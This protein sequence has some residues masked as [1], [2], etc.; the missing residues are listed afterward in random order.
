MGARP[1]PAEVLADLALL[2]SMS[3]VVHYFWG[4]WGILAALA[5]AAALEHGPAA[6]HDMSA[7]LASSQLTSSAISDRLWGPAS[8]LGPAEDEGDETRIHRRQNEDGANQAARGDGAE[9]LATALSDT[10]SSSSASLPVLPTATTATNPFQGRRRDNSTFG[11]SGDSDAIAHDANVSRLRIRDV[12]SR[13]TAAAS[14]IRPPLCANSPAPIP[15]ETDLFVGHV[16]FLV[17]TPS[18]SPSAAAEAAA[19]YAELFEGKRRMFWIQVQGRFKRAPRGAVFLGGE[20]PARIAPGFFTR[21]LALVIVGLIRQLL[22]VGNV[23]FSFGDDGREENPSRSRSARRGS[24][25]R[26]TRELPAISFPLYQSVD[27]FVDT[28]E[29]EEP[30]ELGSIDFGETLEMRQRRRQTPLGAEKFVVGNTYSFHFHTMYVDLTKW[31]TVNLPGLSAMDLSAFFDSLPLRLVAYDVVNLI[32]DDKH[33]QVDKD[34]LFSFEIQYDR[35]RTGFDGGRS[36]TR[37]ADTN[38]PVEDDDDDDLMM[39]VSS[40]SSSSTR[41]SRAAVGVGGPIGSDLSTRS[42]TNVSDELIS[43]IDDDNLSSSLS[44]ATGEM[45]GTVRQQ[46][47]QF[48]ARENARRLARLAPAFL[49]WMEE[50]DLDS[51]VRGIHYVFSVSDLSVSDDDEEIE[52]EEDGSRRETREHS[53]GQRRLT[54]VS[55]HALRSVL[56]GRDK[57]KRMASHYDKIKSGSNSV[58]EGSKSTQ[59]RQELQAMRFHTHSRIG[60]YSSITDEVLEVVDHLQALLLAGRSRSNAAGDDSQNS[61]DHAAGGP[62]PEKDNNP[63]N[64]DDDDN[65]E[66]MAARSALYQALLRRQ[67]LQSPETT[68]ASMSPSRLGVNLSRREREELGVV[69]EGVVYRYYADALLRQEVLQLSADALLFYRSYSPRP[70]KRVASE[71]VIGVRAI[72][73]PLLSPSIGAAELSGVGA[74]ALEISTL[75]EQIVLCLGTAFARDAWLRVLEQHCD[76]RTN[77]TKWLAPAAMMANKP[78]Q[79]QMQME[80]QLRACTTSS[81]PRLLP[82]QRIVLNSW[83]LF[84]SAILSTSLSEK[85]EAS[86]FVE[87]VAQALRQALAIH[88][89]HEKMASSA[90]TAKTTSTK[91]VLAFLER[92]SAVRAIDLQLIQD[93]CSH[94]QQLA[95][96]LNL[97]HLMLA[98]AMMAHGFPRG[99]RGWDTFLRSMSYSLQRQRPRRR[100]HHH[101]HHQDSVG[102]AR[103]TPVKGYAQVTVSLAELEHLLLRARMPRADIPHLRLST[104]ARAPSASRLAG[105]GLR[106]PDFR[107]SLALA[108]NQHSEHRVRVFTAG[109]EIHAQLNAVASALL[110]SP[111]GLIEVRETASV[112]RLPRVCEWYRRDFGRSPLNALR[113]LLGFLDGDLQRQVLRLLEREQPVHLEYRSFK[114]TPKDALLLLDDDDDDAMAPEIEADDAGDDVL[115]R[116]AGEEGSRVTADGGDEDDEDGNEAGD[117]DGAAQVSDVHATTM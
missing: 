33:A 43:E 87:L 68:A 35:H 60:S 94:E 65:E 76:P 88:A 103:D 2:S 52:L 18:S 79:L 91:Q 115:G 92:A 30:P 48:L 110:H 14:P 77:A 104:M 98:H 101:H 5:L 114:Y 90:S 28:P 109:P 83:S 111:S 67:W 22:P 75:G 95:F 9:A 84:P 59:R 45:D 71:S 80:Q 63:D 64:G 96:Y 99:R 24:A 51:G 116:D 89:T 72:P 7:A 41:G 4:V 23:H 85:E 78:R 27:Q 62:D 38:E 1:Q 34:Y 15:F 13:P 108:T 46:H 86:R 66:V 26:Q 106:H 69:F 44:T 29:G 6:Y 57:G 93:A 107:V 58:S 53:V 74:F 31:E 32:D 16:L 3:A 47:R 11:G 50:L 40:S 10:T 97:Y 100:H 12:G 113:K 117:A 42:S 70:E 112:V 82:A 49:C 37:I 61:S 102:D 17:R 54:I 39:T 20:L 8:V 19:P 55:A 56:V 105:L 21:S 25:S 73:V 36:R 81:G